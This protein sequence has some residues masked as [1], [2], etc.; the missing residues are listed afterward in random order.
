MAFYYLPEQDCSLVV[1]HELIEKDRIF[2]RWFGEWSKDYM[3]MKTSSI[4]KLVGIWRW[5]QRVHIL[6]QHAG[7]EMLNVENYEIEE[8]EE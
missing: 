6:R 4:S 1:Y 8:Q 5:E 3:V 7:L 2:G